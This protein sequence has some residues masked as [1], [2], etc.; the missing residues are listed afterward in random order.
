MKRSALI[1]GIVIVALGITA[2][3]SIF[4]IRMGEQAL[5]TQ[6]GDPR[7]EVK[8]PGLHFKLPFIQEVVYFDKRILDFDANA[9]EIPTS[10]QK[11]LVV[12]SFARYRIVEPLAFY[13]TVSN[14]SNA[15]SQ[16]NNIISSNL[17][18][19]FGQSSLA[20]LMTA[21]RAELLIAIS[22][23]VDTGSRH[24]GI[25][26]VDVRIK[27]VDLPEENSQAIFR[28]MQTQREQ[29]ARQIRAEGDR[30]AR[31]IRADADKQQRIIIADAKKTGEILRG[32]GDAGATK[33]YNDAYGRD[34]DFFDFFRSMQAM[35][36]GLTGD[37]TRYVGPP[38][39]DFYRFFQSGEGSDVGEGDKK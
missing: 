16:L 17:R 14:E 23:A 26:V 22:K 2:F 36:K 8:D 37:S 10:D 25:E 1:A 30:D 15:Q 19:I 18:E 21:K 39:G 9:E 34:R 13:Q 3:S 29:E 35:S 11:Q 27:R 32:E 6:F 33:L 7:R 38:K 4:V 31:R 12:D 24:L 28:R 20:T 5:V